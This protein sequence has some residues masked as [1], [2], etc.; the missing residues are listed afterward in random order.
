MA[1]AA[2]ILGLGVIFN[3]RNC[4]SAVKLVWVLVVFLG[5]FFFSQLLGLL[6]NNLVIC[7]VSVTITIS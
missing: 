6:L 3:W 5:C 4:Y 7:L 1:I 2:S